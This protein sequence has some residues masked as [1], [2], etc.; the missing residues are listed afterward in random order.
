MVCNRFQNE[1]FQPKIE[2]SSISFISKQKQKSLGKTEKKTKQ[3]HSTLLNSQNK[4][5]AKMGFYVI[6][7]L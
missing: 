1:F 3:N 5:A 7:T 6:R 2:F 4:F